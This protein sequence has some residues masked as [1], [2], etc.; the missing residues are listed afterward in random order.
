MGQ[1]RKIKVEL[2]VRFSAEFR[3]LKKSSGFRPD[4]VT[5]AADGGADD[6]VKVF[7]F[8]RNRRKEMGK[9]IFPEPAPSCMDKTGDP[10][11]VYQHRY[12][13]G[14]ENPEENVTFPTYCCIPVFPA[15]ALFTTDHG[16]G[17]NLVDKKH[18]IKLQTPGQSLQ[19]SFSVG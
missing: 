7:R 8:F 9:D 5:I 15:I 17:M 12:A 11:S 19:F 1:C 13:I 2:A 3:G 18:M 6:C 10:A 4:F 16:A 14:R